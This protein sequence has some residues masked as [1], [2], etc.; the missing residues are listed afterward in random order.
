MGDPVTVTIVQS[1][2]ARG[3]VV[4]ERHLARFVGR[5]LC[6]VYCPRV[7]VI[8]WALRGNRHKNGLLHEIAPSSVSCI[9]RTYPC[10]VHRM[11]SL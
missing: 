7:D 3:V 11:L 1:A 5:G 8:R 2:E 10:I 4:V 6:E 9:G